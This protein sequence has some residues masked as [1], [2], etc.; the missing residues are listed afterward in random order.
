MSSPQSAVKVLVTGEPG[1]GKTTAVC[2]FVDALRADGVGVDGFLTHEQRRD[3]HRVGFVVRDLRGDQAVLAHQDSDSP[4][5]VGRFG[6]DVDA[7]ARVA[8]PA[9]RRAIESADI[10]VIDE[11]ARMELACP[12]FSELVSAAM[13]SPRPV[14]A[15]VQARSTPFTDDL[16]R[17]PQVT[18]VTVDASGRARVPERLRRLLGFG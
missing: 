6:V 7:F 17:E 5:R 11:I 2:Q 15:T 1:S 8:M 14:V 16:K 9:L 12:G 3:G 10:I 4:V 18:V 13:A